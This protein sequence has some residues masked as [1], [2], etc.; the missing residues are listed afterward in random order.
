MSCFIVQV[1]IPTVS[2]N[3]IAGNLS[4]YANK[5]IMR[6]FLVHIIVGIAI[7]EAIFRNVIAQIISKII[8]E[9]I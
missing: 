6:F 5:I 7:K 9:I 3:N 1:A 2:D 4:I 8:I